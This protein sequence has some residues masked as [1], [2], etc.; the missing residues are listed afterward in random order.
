LRDGCRK[1]LR[2]F[3]RTDVKAIK[4]KDDGVILDVADG[5]AV[6]AERVVFATGY[7]THSFLKQ[8]VARLISTFAAYFALGYGGNGITFSLLAAEI[9]RDAMLGQEN[10]NADLF[11][12]DR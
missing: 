5:C 6:R 12:F 3:D 10:D 8:K 11:R 4:A 7:E 9:I 2:V 1:G